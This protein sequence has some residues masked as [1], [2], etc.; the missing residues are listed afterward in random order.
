[1]G[2]IPF[3]VGDSVDLVVTVDFNS[4]IWS[5]DATT[6]SI[7]V[8]EQGD[9]WV[10]VLNTSGCESSDTT[11]VTTLLNPVI[12]VQTDQDTVLLGQSAQL[13]A[14][15]A[16]TFTWKPGETL[17][18]PDIADPLASPATTTTYTVTGTDLDGCTG[19]AEIT[20]FVQ[21]TGDVLPITAPKMFSP[22]DDTID[23]F[24]VIKNM[25]NF[26][27][28]KVV[29]FS[30]NGNTVFEA[31]PYNNDWN[32]VSDSGEVL[33]EGAYFYVITCDD[34]KSSTGSVSIIR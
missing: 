8:R 22:N 6:S 29:I 3:C 13:Q 16:T 32:G 23:D 25:L 1:M 7:T 17:D 28:C 26:P 20:I 30:R 2:T 15:G 11:T 27:D 19:S 5:T 14:S 21:D 9:Y 4:Y 18:D 33:S 24:W 34:G 12:T 31:K 10:T